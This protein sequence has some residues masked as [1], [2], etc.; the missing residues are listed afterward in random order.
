MKVLGLSADR[1]LSPDCQQACL[2]QAERNHRL[3]CCMSGASNHAK[4]SAHV[5]SLKA[6]AV[7]MDM[8]SNGALLHAGLTWKDCPLKA[9]AG[10][11]PIYQ[12]LHRMPST[13]A[14]P[15]RA[16][17]EAALLDPHQAHHLQQI[18]LLRISAA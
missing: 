17:Q 12:L 13:E 1:F 14:V 9:A 3:L 8:T 2:Y 16:I 10:L 7:L 5:L 11:K 6:K 15:S 18:C 4:Q